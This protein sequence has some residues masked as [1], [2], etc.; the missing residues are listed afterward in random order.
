MIFYLINQTYVASLDELE[1]LTREGNSSDDRRNTM[2]YM[3]YMCVR[4]KS[5]LLAKMQILYFRTAG[6]RKH[7]YGRRSTRERNKG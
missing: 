4:Y 1:K 6:Y 5:V 7:H 3:I 2:S